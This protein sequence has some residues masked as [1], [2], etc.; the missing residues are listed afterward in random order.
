MLLS[1]G[2]HIQLSNKADDV[3]RAVY[4]NSDYINNAS[5]S[6]NGLK[7]RRVRQAGSNKPTINNK[8]DKV[9]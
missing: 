3:D 2:W 1:E 9:K 6:N 8:D 7:D 5:N 4:S